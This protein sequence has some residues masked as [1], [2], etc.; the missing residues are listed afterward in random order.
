MENERFELKNAANIVEMA[1]SSSKMMRN[2]KDNGQDRKFKK[3]TKRKK[4][5]TMDSPSRNLPEKMGHVI[6]SFSKHFEKKNI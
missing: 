4:Q 2:S 3:K 5:I 1:A 6:H